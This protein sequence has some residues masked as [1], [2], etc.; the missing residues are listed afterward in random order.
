[1]KRCDHKTGKEHYK[2]KSKEKTEYWVSSSLL[3]GDCLSVEL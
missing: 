1:M 2:E 3:P